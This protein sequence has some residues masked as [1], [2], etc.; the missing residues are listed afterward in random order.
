MKT[1]VKQIIASIL[2]ASVSMATEIQDLIQDTQKL[3][4]KDKRINLVWWIPKEFWQVSL[5]DN[6]SLTEAQK[7]E[8][9]STLENYTAFAVIV[10][11]VGILGGMNFKTRDEILA[12]IQLKIK[13]KEINP[14]AHKDLTPD[15]SNLFASMKPTMENMLGK[16]GQGMEF[17]VYKNKDKEKLIIDPKKPGAFI[18]ESF[19]VEHTWRLPLGSLLPPKFDKESGEMFPGNYNFNPFTGAKL[20][21][22]K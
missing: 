18:F 11:D 15:A 19:G 21:D 4:Q 8:F 17:V 22:K 9:V 20:I 13:N 14:I 7:K 1:I 6:P 12:N 5:K 2:F 10:G 3:I 16:F